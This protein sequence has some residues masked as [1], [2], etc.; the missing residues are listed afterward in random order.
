MPACSLFFK[1]VFGNDGQIVAVVG[2]FL[3]QL[4]TDAAGRACDDGQRR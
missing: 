4:V 3:S 1:L 2:K